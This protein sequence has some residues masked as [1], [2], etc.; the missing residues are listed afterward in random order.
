MEAIDIENEI[1]LTETEK[2]KLENLQ[3]QKRLLEEEMKKLSMQQDFQL[4]SISKRVDK[5]LRGWTIDLQKGIC[6]KDE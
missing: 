3:L 2:L 5:D 4:A 6:F 1:E